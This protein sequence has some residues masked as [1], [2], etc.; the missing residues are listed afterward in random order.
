MYKWRELL[1]LNV[2]L[3]SDIQVGIVMMGIEVLVLGVVEDY[4]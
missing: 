3:M 2:M 4:F 1:Q